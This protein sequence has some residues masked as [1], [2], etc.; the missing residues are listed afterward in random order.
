ML[1]ELL[2]FFFLLQPFIALAVKCIEVENLTDIYTLAL[3][4]YAM[5]LYKP[6]STFTH[7]LI[8]RLKHTAVIEGK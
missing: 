7:A 8:E 2:F 1:G 3:T 4:T 5:T 6:T